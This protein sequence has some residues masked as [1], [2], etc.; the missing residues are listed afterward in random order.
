MLHYNYVSYK[1]WQKCHRIHS[2]A[3]AGDDDN[4]TVG[5]QKFKY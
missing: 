2:D 3:E 4:A 5:F 1:K